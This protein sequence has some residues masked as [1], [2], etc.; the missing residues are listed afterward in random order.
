M[1]HLQVDHR[2]IYGLVRY[3]KKRKAE[4][5]VALFRKCLE[6]ELQ[7]IG[8]LNQE[9]ILS[10]TLL[11]MFILLFKYRKQLQLR[12]NPGVFAVIWCHSINIDL[13]IF[14]KKCAFDNF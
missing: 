13:L 3:F 5:R 2:E 1:L 8:R 10:I 7:L 11:S 6:H 12:R 4:G 14:R 9:L